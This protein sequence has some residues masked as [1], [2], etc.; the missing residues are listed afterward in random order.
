M[1]HMLKLSIIVT[2]VLV[3]LNG[4][5]LHLGISGNNTDG[6][7]WLKTVIVDYT[8]WQNR[9]S[10]LVDWLEE[11]TDFSILGH[12]PLRSDRI[13]TCYFD[14]WGLGETQ[15][16]NDIYAMLDLFNW[17][18][19]N[20]IAREEM[21]LHA[22]TDYSMEHLELDV[23]ACFDQ[24]GILE[25]DTGGYGYGAQNG[26]L[27]YN[28]S[29]Y[30][31]CSVE[32]YQ[33]NDVIA[34]SAGDM[35][36]FGYLEAYMQINFELQTSASGLNCTFEYFDGSAWQPLS[37]STDSTGNF[38]HAGRIEFLPPADWQRTSVNSSPAKYF[39]RLVFH[40]AAVYPGISF[41]CGEDWARPDTN[42][43]GHL[44]ELKGWDDTAAGVNTDNPEFSYNASPPA[45]A[46]ARFRYQSRIPFWHGRNFIMN[47][48]DRQSVN[49]SPEYTWPLYAA[50]GIT[51]RI[52]ID[53]GYDGVMCDDAGGIIPSYVDEEDTDFPEKVD[54]HSTSDFELIR[55]SAI[56]DNVHTLSPDS[57]IGLN[58]YNPEVVFHGDF[59][60]VEYISYITNGQHRYFIGPDDGLDYEWMIEFD[61]YLPEHNPAG[62]FGVM[63]WADNANPAIGD[64][65]RYD[66]DKANRGPMACLSSHYISMN[67]NTRYFMYH[68]QP[69]FGFTYGE[70][71]ELYL[72]NGDVIHRSEY[73]GTSYMD[74]LH[75]T[76]ADI[77]RW[78]TFFPAMRT[79]IGRPDQSGYN[80][81]HRD[82]TW[83]DAM[84]GSSDMGDIW[85]RDFDKAV[86]FYRNDSMG[87]SDDYSTYCKPIRL[88]RV[89]YPLRADGTT[90]ESTNELTLRQNEG[91]IYMK[92]AI[93]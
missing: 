39:T 69:G 71:D 17:C 1:K 81:G 34:P 91:A 21:F 62:T 32:I 31:D 88:N 89:Y 76:L 45:G 73:E 70:T 52:A 65:E 40:S 28:G 63:M 74:D 18:N 33:Q 68:S 29:T 25:N 54:G 15:R 77:E 30:E 79:D 2:A 47:T 59:N 42:N 36:F 3:F 41:I 87:D 80:N 61:D 14:I 58:A 66:W 82:L 7:P 16:I 10:D 9:S 12:V 24:F 8:S 43:D 48:A 67:E 38:A 78:G 92:F 49:G 83:A 93:Q 6:T 37:L 60:I 27:Y 11:R 50:R 57:L 44:N 64:L 56:H 51:G 26:V 53:G 20:G 75:I 85:R 35:I 86:A 46:S 4:C 19:E 55:F 23:W 13:R 22:K 72:K 5:N 84:H 90:G